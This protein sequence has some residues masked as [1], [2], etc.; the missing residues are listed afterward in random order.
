MEICQDH[1]HE[2]KNAIRQRGMWKLVSSNPTVSPNRGTPSTGA[3]TAFDPLAI[4][5]RM[6]A[7]Q[8][9]MA[10]GDSLENRSSCPLCEVEQ[11]LGSGTS[12]EWIDVN[13]DTLLQL[14]RERHLLGTEESI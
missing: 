3:E 13:A 1:W 5:G 8:A 12:N 10:L 9:H 11:N 4:A 2:L 14:C 7:H 6:I